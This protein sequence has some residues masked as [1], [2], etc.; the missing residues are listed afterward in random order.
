MNHETWIA[1]KIVG[2][3]MS[4]LLSGLSGGI[5]IGTFYIPKKIVEKG[6]FIAGATVAFTSIMMTGIF[7]QV[8]IDFLELDQKYELGIAFLIGGLALSI[9]NW[10][11]N[12][13]RTTDDMIITEVIEDVTEEIKHLKEGKN[14]KQK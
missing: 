5:T 3:K 12:W 1:M 9:I 10:A 8:I 4:T 2:V 7:T 11:T 14:A 6:V 13:L